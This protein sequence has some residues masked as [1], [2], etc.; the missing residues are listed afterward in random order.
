MAAALVRSG[1]KV[2]TK[3]DDDRTVLHLAAMKG[4]E[5]V[6]EDI[7]KRQVVEIDAVDKYGDTALQLAFR[8]SHP[9][10]AVALVR[11]GAK[12][13]TK[14]DEDRTI[15]HLAA[16]KGNEEFTEEILKRQVVEIDAVDK[17][18]NTALQL[19][20]QN[21]HPSVA[22]AL[23]R[24]GA[25]ADTKDDEDRTL[26]HLA[27]MK[28]NKEVTE[29]ILKR[30]VVEIDAVDKYGHTALHYVCYNS[31][32][33]TA[34]KLIDG[35]AEVNLKNRKGKTPLHKAAEIGHA[36][37][38]TTLLEH[39][40]DVNAVDESGKTALETCHGTAIKRMLRNAM[41]KQ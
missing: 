12:A 34:L 30:Q 33:Q 32:C 11:G 36:E 26:L 4:N 41:S 22:A 16:M 21:P 40:A 14:D 13:D 27:A 6:T 31:D 29:E 7:L 1:A 8:T 3:D 5:E 25:K 23:V 28:G 2:D 10:V 37:L 20:I 18:G 24:S 38:T 17:S 9:G 19:A 35:G 39:N 15:L